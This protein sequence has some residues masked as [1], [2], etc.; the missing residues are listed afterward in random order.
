MNLS[1]FLPHRQSGA[2]LAT[3]CAAFLSV[4]ASETQAQNSNNNPTKQELLV[5]QAL[6]MFD[7]QTNYGNCAAPNDLIAISGV[8]FDNGKRPVVM[9]GG[10][11]PLEICSYSDD[12]IL[13]NC[14]DGVCFAGDYLLEIITGNAVKDY[15]EFDL[16]IGMTGPQGVAGAQGEQGVPGEQGETGLQGDQGEIGPQGPQGEPGPRGSQGEQGLQGLAGADGAP[17]A[18]GATGPQGPQGIPGP[19]GLTGLPG[20]QGQQ[21]IQGPKG[22]TG[23]TGPQGDST[24]VQF[25]TKASQETFIL[26]GGEISVSCDAGD[27]MT[28]GSC[29]VT[30]NP[31]FPAFAISSAFRLLLPPAG[32]GAPPVSV[33]GWQCRKDVD[34]VLNRTLRVE[35]YC[36]VTQP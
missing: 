36:V 5:N 12:I 19:R 30:N 35:A 4:Q 34:S 1:K 9:L 33:S 11:G 15:D 14:P 3:I 28:G 13:A 31:V 17:G 10:E 18:P 21:G 25:Y 32:P 6:V 7:N 24:S 23:A 26:G 22:D 2:L 29:S 16:T 27:H 8:N 20:S